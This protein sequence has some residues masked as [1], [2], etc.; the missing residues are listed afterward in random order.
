M[1]AESQPCILLGLNKPFFFKKHT[2]LELKNTN[3]SLHWSIHGSEMKFKDSVLDQHN[4]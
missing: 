2:C 1:F 4:I 3:P